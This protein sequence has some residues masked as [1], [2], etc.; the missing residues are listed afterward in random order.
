MVQLLMT[1]IN[2]H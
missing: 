2:C 1:A